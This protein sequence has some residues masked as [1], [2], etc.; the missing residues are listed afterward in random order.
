MKTFFKLVGLLLIA[1]ITLVPLAISAETPENQKSNVRAHG[2]LKQCHR[3]PRAVILLWCL[4]ATIATR[5]DICNWRGKC[6]NQTG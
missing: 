1:I 6:L 4:D 3:W 5:L 2:L